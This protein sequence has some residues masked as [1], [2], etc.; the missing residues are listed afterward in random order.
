MSYVYPLSRNA[1]DDLTGLLVPLL[2]ERLMN[3]RPMPPQTLRLMIL[4]LVS[5]A[6][7]GIGGV[8][9]RMPAA[10][11]AGLLLVGIG[12]GIVLHTWLRDNPK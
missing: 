7:V 11:P 4:A 2:S 5:L 8:L 1:D 3:W 10:L 12:V 6:A 9:L